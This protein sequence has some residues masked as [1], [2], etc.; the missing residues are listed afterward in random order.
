MSDQHD[1]VVGSQRYTRIRELFVQVCELDPVERSAILDSA[2]ADDLDLRGEVESLLREDSHASGIVGEHQQRQRMVVSMAGCAAVS[3]I[4]TLPCLF[5]RYRLLRVLGEGGMGTVYEA[6]QVHPHRLVALKVLRPGV[7]TAAML[8]RFEHEAHVLGLLHHPGI[9]QIF[10]AGTADR[11]QGEQPF[12]VMELVRGQPLLKYAA[13]RGLSVR[14][15]LELMARICDAVQHAHAKGVVHR[16]LKPNNIFVEETGQPKILDFGVARATDCD[17]QTTTLHTQVGQLV[18]TLAYMSPEQAGGNPD[19]VDTRSD[20]YSL[21]VICYELLSGRLPLDLDRKPLHEA[22]RMIREQEPPKLGALDRGFR[23]DVETIVAKAMEKEPGLRYQ[24]AAELGADVHRFMNAETI[25]ARSASVSSLMWKFAQRHR[26]LSIAAVAVCAALILGAAATFAALAQATRERDAARH[27]EAVSEARLREVEQS[28]SEARQ[29]Q[30]EAAAV[31]LFLQEMLASADPDT[32]RGEDISVRTVLDRAA[33]VVASQFAANDLV[34]ASIHHTIAITYEGIGD[35]ESALTHIK[36]AIEIRDARLGRGD[37]ETLESTRVLAGILQRQGHYSDAVR[38]MQ[39]V[40]DLALQ[41]FGPD[42]ET[43]LNA[44]MSLASALHRE[45]KHRETCLL[46][47]DAVTR[48]Q[49]TFG[50]DHRS[51]LNAMRTLA[52]AYVGSGRWNEARELFAD[53]DR[54]LT[55]TLG[56]THPITLATRHGLAYAHHETGDDAKAELILRKTLA[57]R[58][59]VLG[60]AHQDTLTTMNVLAGVVMERGELAEAQTLLERVAE[61]RATVLGENHPDTLNSLNQL[62]LVQDRRGQWARSA[63]TFLLVY[64]RRLQI[65]GER[66]PQTITSQHNWGTALSRLGRYA[67]AEPLQRQTLVA[68]GELLGEDHPQTIQAAS[69]LAQ[70]LRL[71]GKFVEAVVLLRNVVEW[72]R[73]HRGVSHKDSRSAMYLLCI[74]LRLSGAVDEA[75]DL[76]HTLVKAGEQ[77]LPETDFRRSLYQ[78]QE[79]ACLVERGQYAEAEPV[80][81]AAYDHV[82]RERGISD[83]NLRDVAVILVDLYERS[84]RTESAQPY[85]EILA[86]KAGGST[87]P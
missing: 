29:A 83:R 4:E 32:S 23:G 40:L 14:E 51:T 37:R 61:L 86:R 82:V 44:T 63:E 33:P 54:R 71:Q 73:Q 34:R 85:Q 24:S 52:N 1:S 64:Q 26:S 56:E 70:T 87:D 74:S 39:E 36:Q 66:H 13:E 6:E 41:N 9:A 45:G 59:S 35:L 30:Q 53:A 38:M 68:R 72:Q 18:G 76:A 31:N 47:E 80:L 12:F 21:G 57:D 27:A 62:G 3:A 10:E 75:C 49:R 69:N 15:K 58:Q 81:I 84:G 16:D 11:G 55:L 78:A 67:E 60:D 8:R 65:L 20:V 28:Q 19:D 22:V 25:S 77:S 42:H 48:F 50:V 46:L 2:C 5:G 17:I 7:T 43:T 79:A